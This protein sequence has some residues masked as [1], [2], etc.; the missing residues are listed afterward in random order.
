[1]ARLSRWKNER[2][3]LG[4]L[5]VR[6]SGTFHHRTDAWRPRPDGGDLGGCGGTVSPSVAG[7]LVR[8]RKE[9]RSRREARVTAGECELTKPFPKGRR[10]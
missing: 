1:M 7:R 4:P 3:P 9:G 6:I 10:R 2:K 8:K 5:V